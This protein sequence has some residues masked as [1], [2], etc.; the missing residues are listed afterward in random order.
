MTGMMRQTMRD[1]SSEGSGGSISQ[2]EVWPTREEASRGIQK[3]IIRQVNCRFRKTGYAA[4]LQF[5][6]NNATGALLRTKG[7]RLIL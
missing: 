1:L 7:R 4:I 3:W 6:S 2:D 5:D